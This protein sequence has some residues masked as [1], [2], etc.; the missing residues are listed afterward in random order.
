MRRK[1]VLWGSNEK[2][3]KMLVALELQEKERLAA[4]KYQMESK[5]RN[6]YPSNVIDNIT[7]KIELAERFR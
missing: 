1:L 5:I 3:E 6:D 4:I 2:D 7:K